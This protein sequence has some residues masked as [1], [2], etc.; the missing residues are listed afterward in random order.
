MGSIYSMTL[1][2]DEELSLIT[3]K[4]QRAVCEVKDGVVS[5]SLGN[6]IVVAAPSELTR[7]YLE[8]AFGEL[9]DLS[10]SSVFSACSLPA[11]R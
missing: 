4:E 5:V 9:R 10:G 7:D 8:E 1:W 11:D 2:N 3:D 6:G